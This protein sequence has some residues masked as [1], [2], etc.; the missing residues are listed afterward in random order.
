HSFIYG[1]AKCAGMG[2]LEERISMDYAPRKIKLPENMTAGTPVP[3][4]QEFIDSNHHVNN[5]QYVDVAVNIIE[6]D[7]RS[8]G[9]PDVAAEIK[10]EK[11]KDS[12]IFV[13]EIRV[14]YKKQAVL[15]DI[16]YP[17]TCLLKDWY[18]VTF[19]DLGGHIYASVAIRL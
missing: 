10:S 6:K 18:Y 9:N 7:L 19:T 3:V 14:E 12:K 13:K 16:L 1:G 4:I 15:G 17:K 5:A 8:F 2:V 11:H